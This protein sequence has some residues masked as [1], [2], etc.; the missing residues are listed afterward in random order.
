[1]RCLKALGD[2][3]AARDPDRQTTEIRIRIALMKPVLGLRHRKDAVRRGMTSAG[4][5]RRHVATPW[6]NAKQ[7]PQYP[8]HTDK[9]ISRHRRSHC[10]PKNQHFSRLGSVTSF[11]RNF[12]RILHVTVKSLL[13][14]PEIWLAFPIR[15]PSCLI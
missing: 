2:R 3:I 11:P 6:G 10:A 9:Q 4:V 12:S 13:P 8:R 1:M 5:R 15:D 7:T 14:T